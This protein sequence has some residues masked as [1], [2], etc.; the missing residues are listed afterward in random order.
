MADPI[1]VPHATFRQGESWTPGFLIQDA[2]EVALSLTGAG[3]DVTLRLYPRQ[4]GT[5]TTRKKSVAGEY[6]YVTDGTDGQIQFLFSAAQTAALATG[7]YAVEV[8]YENTAPTPD[9]K[10]VKGHGWAQ[11]LAPLTGTL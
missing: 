10:I 1:L 7:L 6:A 8:V 9:A 11:I 2:D 3:V 5:V 4:G